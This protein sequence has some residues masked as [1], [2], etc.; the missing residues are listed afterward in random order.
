[1]ETNHTNYLPGHQ[2][3]IYDEEPSFHIPAMA[4]SICANLAAKKRCLYFNSNSMLSVMRDRLSTDGLDLSHQL[5]TGALVMSTE[6]PQLVKGI[7]DIDGMIDMLEAA[8]KDAQ[9][10]GY[11]G[12]WS[13]GDVYWE[14]GSKLNFDKLFEHE[15]RLDEF[16]SRSE[17]FSCVCQYNRNSLAPS[18]VNTAL[19]VHPAVYI[20]NTLSHENTFYK[21]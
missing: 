7:F 6:R 21:F 11:A 9:A 16:M 17:F 20:S 8:V 2:C 1:M 19:A 14:L 18:A 12:L 15:R 5:S 3:L 10:D 4:R 13:T